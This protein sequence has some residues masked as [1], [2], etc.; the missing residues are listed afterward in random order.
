MCIKQDNTFV[1]YCHRRNGPVFLKVRT[2]TNYI[3]QLHIISRLHAAESSTGRTGD[4]AQTIGD[5]T[6]RNSLF[7]M[8]QKFQQIPHLNSNLN[9]FSLLWIEISDKSY[10]FRKGEAIVPTKFCH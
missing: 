10:I 3:S 8:F 4:C 6:G 1:Q 9:V 7:P 5:T 2:G